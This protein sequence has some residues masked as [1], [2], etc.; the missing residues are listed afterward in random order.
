M[1]PI[2]HMQSLADL[3]PHLRMYT[4]LIDWFVDGSWGFVQNEWLPRFSLSNAIHENSL[5]YISKNDFNFLQKTFTAKPCFQLSRFSRL[6]ESFST[7]N[8]PAQRMTLI[9]SIFLVQGPNSVMSQAFFSFLSISF[10]KLL[11]FQ[12][13]VTLR[14]FIFILFQLTSMQHWGFQHKY[15]NKELYRE[16][17]YKEPKDKLM[18]RSNIFLKNIS[19]QIYLFRL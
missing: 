2:P 11:Y 18:K 7:L 10:T 8:S 14:L 15:L 1:Y 9:S 3:M 4:E 6:L 5:S 13:W 16:T 17:L 19:V 12:I